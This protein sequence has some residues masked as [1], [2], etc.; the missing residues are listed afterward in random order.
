MSFLQVYVHAVWSTHNREPIL[1][2]EPM[3]S[4]CSFINQYAAS[5]DI[6]ILVVNGWLD[7]LHCL[8]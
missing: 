5:K 6:R 1:K 7:H 3:K 4:I 2:P 8:F